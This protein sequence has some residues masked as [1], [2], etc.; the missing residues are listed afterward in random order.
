MAKKKSIFK[1]LFIKM[2][3]IKIKLIFK[4]INKT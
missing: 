2:I 1:D 4:K 3:I